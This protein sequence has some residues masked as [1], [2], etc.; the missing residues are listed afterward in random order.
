MKNVGLDDLIARFIPSVLL[1]LVASAVSCLIAWGWAATRPN[2]YVSEIELQVQWPQALATTSAD[3]QRSATGKLESPLLEQLIT[4]EDF[5]ADMR[6][7]NDVIQVATDLRKRISVSLAGRDLVRLRYAADDPRLAQKLLD[8]VA[9]LYE[10]KK[11]KERASNLKEAETELAKQENRLRDF[12]TRF[13][14]PQ[15]QDQ[16]SNLTALNRLILRMQAS[17]GGLHIL[18]REKLQNPGQGNTPSEAQQ[19]E[20]GTA[21]SDA[22]TFGEIA[23]QGLTR[24]SVDKLNR[25][26]EQRLREQEALRKQMARYSAKI[27][28]LPRIRQQQQ[29]ITTDYETAKRLYEGVLTEA[30]QIQA[31]QSRG[32]GADRFRFRVVAPASFPDEVIG[33]GQLK[34]ASLGSLIGLLLGVGVV[35]ARKPKRDEVL[36]LDELTKLTGLSVLASIPWLTIVD[37]EGRKD[38]K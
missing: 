13:F 5:F 30:S 36:S 38:T 3:L 37:A 19:S 21:P 14:G 17:V 25:E 33:K 2:M 4:E 26:I 16:T 9:C 18:Q 24:G 20:V 7:N 29:S 31:S 15:L 8:E 22:Q 34:S 6:R 28:L 35:L 10:T 1:V 23:Q 12:N 27:D 32:G 11:D